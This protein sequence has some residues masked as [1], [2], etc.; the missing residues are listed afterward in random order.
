[1]NEN[2]WN[3]ATRRACADGGSNMLKTYSDEINR[4][5]LPDYISGDFDSIDE[6]TLKYYQ[7]ISSVK[8]I[9]TQD[10]NATDFTKCVR[11]M[12]DQQSN[13]TDLL[14]F[15]SLSGRF[16]HTI[17]IIHSLYVLNEI[18]P[19]LQIYLF[20]DCDISFLLHAD[21]LNRIDVQSK[22]RG[23][24]CSLLPFGRSAHVQTEG[25]KWNLTV[26]Q[27]LGFGKLVSSSNTY[28]NAQTNHV[29]VRTDADIVWSMT[30][31]QN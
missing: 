20:T 27:E 28:E 17:G 2:L 22:Y 16:D 6:Q 8:F 3:Q 7:S 24:V 31:R 4:T 23:N 21:R 25:L 12:M 19:N 10:Q 13:L 15:C 30:Y 14:V 9:H 11:V 29:D 26:E 18:H 1:M 5:L